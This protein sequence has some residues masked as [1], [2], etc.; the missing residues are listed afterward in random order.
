MGIA[1][2][3]NFLNKH[4]EARIFLNK[5][6]ESKLSD[7]EYRHKWRSTIV[8][9]LDEGNIKEAIATLKTQQE[10]S[11]NGNNN[12]EPSFHIYYSYLRMVRLYFENNQGIKGFEAYENWNKYVQA[13]SK[14]ESTKQRVQSLK[15][16]YMAYKAYI[17]NDLESA[18]NLLESYDKIKGKQLDASRTLKAKILIKKKEYNKAAEFLLEGDLSSYYN[19]YWLTLALIGKKDFVAAQKWKH[20]IINKNER[21]DINLALVRQKAKNLDL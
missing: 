17:E 7:Y 9:Y 18:I 20:K 16:Y 13:N 6:N 19:Q 1:A 12:R 8:S 10:E 15:N 14:R 21:N 5:L 4:K 11:L 2:N 3:L